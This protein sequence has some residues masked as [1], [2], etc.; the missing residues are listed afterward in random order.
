M[1]LHLELG[2][3]GSLKARFEYALR[4][5]VRALPPEARLPP[6]RAL[7]TELG[8][9]RGVVVEA[10]AQLAAEGYLLTRRG[11]GTFVAH[12]TPAPAAPAA[13]KAR[14]TASPA[15]RPASHP[16]RARR[17]LPPRLGQGAQP[18]AA[19]DAG[20]AARLPRRPW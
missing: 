4:A 10:Y 3:T 18:R 12:T 16:A 2:E 15:L 19:H 9:S 1:D 20:R 13:T 14:D 17:R 5:A 7:A 8:V 6:T 11:G